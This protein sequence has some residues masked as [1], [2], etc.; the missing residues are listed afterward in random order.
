MKLPKACT[1]LLVFCSIIA[2]LG[3]PAGCNMERRASLVPVGEMQQYKDP[4]YGFS[5]KY[6]KGWIPN[7]QVGRAHFYSEHGVDMK[8]RDPAGS[9]PLGVVV[10]VNVI[11]A[12]DTRAAKDQVADELVATGSEL[13]KE[14]DITVAERKALKLHYSARTAGNHVIRGYHIL[15]PADSLVYDLG[16]AGFD[17][18]YEAYANVFDAVMKSFTLP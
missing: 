12:P 10:V 13:D 8:F 7:T 4:V 3:V 11:H 5:I 2:V 16:F 1:C 15:V 6:P 18:R 17:D 9:F 14:E